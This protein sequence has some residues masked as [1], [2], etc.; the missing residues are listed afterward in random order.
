MKDGRNSAPLPTIYDIGTGAPLV[1]EHG[2]RVLLWG[3]VEGEGAVGF[4]LSRDGAIQLAW[5]LNAQVAEMDAQRGAM[6]YG[7]R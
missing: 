2:G 6:S 5:R 3:D 7:T 4:R 1:Q